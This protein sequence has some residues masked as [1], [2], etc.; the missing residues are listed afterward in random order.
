MVDLVKIRKKAKEKKSEGPATSPAEPPDRAAEGGGAPPTTKLQRFLETAGK[1]RVIETRSTDEE[2][3]ELELLTFSIAGEFYA[4]DINT[5]VEIVMV[6]PITRIPN[7]DPS[8]VGIFS[9]RGAIVTLIDVR[10]RLGLRPGEGGGL[11]E[12][13]VVVQHAGENMGFIVDRVVRVVKV[14]ADSLEPHP[15]VH[16][17]EQSESVR[18]VFRDAV[19]LAILIDLDRVLNGTLV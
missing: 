19:G 10:G 1:R 17:S 15:V 13:V 5:V 4:I 7:A 8:V 14:D 3:P 18:G 11:D 12:R 9:L 16:A 6:R 2:K